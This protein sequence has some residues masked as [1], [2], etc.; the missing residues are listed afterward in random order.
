MMSPQGQEQPQ[1]PGLPEDGQANDQAAATERL[2]LRA[3]E[4]A[5]VRHSLLERSLG[6]QVAAKLRS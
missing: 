3:V 4:L 1:L 6:A 2:A 5:G